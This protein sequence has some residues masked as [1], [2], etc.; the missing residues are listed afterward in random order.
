MFA[1]LVFDLPFQLLVFVPLLVWVIGPASLHPYVLA[2]TV[3]VAAILAGPLLRRARRRYLAAQAEVPPEDGWR[4]PSG[5]PPAGFIGRCTVFLRQHGWRVTESRITESGDA[6]LVAQKD[7]ARI[8]LHCL[9]PDAAPD[10]GDLASLAAARPKA[11]ATRAALVC[12]GKPPAAML[13]AA[14]RR[15]VLLLRNTEL[16]KYEPLLAER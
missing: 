6:E 13:E 14:S 5:L 15:G 2:A 1:A 12:T 8:L 4:W 7:R 9:R 10:D 16:E 3:L 11:G